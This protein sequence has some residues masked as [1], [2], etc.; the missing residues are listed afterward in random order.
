M[1][2]SERMSKI[3]SVRQ[4]DVLIY[5]SDGSGSQLLIKADPL[6]TYIE[7]FPVSG[8]GMARPLPKSFSPGAVTMPLLTDRIHYKF[9]D[10]PGL[11]TSEWYIESFDPLH[12][13]GAIW[14]TYTGH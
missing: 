13:V 14:E 4:T 10:S 1:T 8:S 5:T 3:R 11:V 2:D 12:V 9:S 7:F 6:R